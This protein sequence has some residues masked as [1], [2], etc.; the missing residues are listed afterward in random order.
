MKR[1]LFFATKWFFTLSLLVLYAGSTC[2]AASPEQAPKKGS[3]TAGYLQN[4]NLTVIKETIQYME[5]QVEIAAEYSCV[6]DMRQTTDSLSAGQY[7]RTENYYKDYPGG[8]AVYLVDESKNAKDNGGT[9]IKL[10]GNLCC[11]LVSDNDTV[12]PMQFG[13]YGDGERDDHDALQA[14]FGSGFGTIALSGRTYLCNDSIW[15]TKSDVSIEGAGATIVCNDSFGSEQAEGKKS[16]TQIYVTGCT[17]ISFFNLRILDGQ[18]TNH[19]R[20]SMGFQAVGNVTM[21]Y[22]TLHIPPQPGFDKDSGS[23]TLSFADG[24]HDVSVRFCEI[25]NESSLKTGGAVGFNDIYAH[26]SENALFEN[27]VVKYNGKDEVIAIFSHTEGG[28]EV[29]H[30]ASYIRNIMIRHNEFYAPRSENWTRDLGFSVGYE[31]S[32][33]V[34]QV[35]YEENYFEVD[36]VWAFMTFSKTSTN[37]AARGNVIH[38]RQTAEN[39]STLSAFKTMGNPTAVVEDNVI[40]MSTINERIPLAVAAGDLVFRN[41][42]VNVNGSI[43]Y[44]FCGGNSSR[45]N[46]IRVEKDVKKALSYQGGDMIE[47]QIIIQGLVGSIYES[48]TMEMKRDI[49]WRG[50]TIQLPNATKT[51]PLFQFNGMKMNGYVF[52]MENNT[53]STPCVAQNALIIGEALKDEDPAEQKILLDGNVF[54]AF[55]QKNY[56]LQIYRKNNTFTLY[57]DTVIKDYEVLFHTED[58]AQV[59]PQS[60]IGG[61]RLLFP[62]AKVIK[63]WKL[64]GWYRD[65]AYLEPWNFEE[66]TVEENLI[67]YGKYVKIPLES[68]CMDRNVITGV[69]GDTV[70]LTPT[71]FPEDTIET[72]LVYESS[73]TTV[74]TVSDDGVVSL[75][76]VGETVI[77]ITA[78]EQNHLRITIP[79]KVEASDNL[80]EEAPAQQPPVVEPP[81]EQE[82]HQEEL[83][84][85]GKVKKVTLKKKTPSSKTS[86]KRQV[87]ITWTSVKGASH[88][89]IYVSTGKGKKY[90]CIATRSAKKKRTYTYT[91]RKGTTIYVKVRAVRKKS[92]E[93]QYGSFSKVKKIK[94]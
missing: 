75:Q 61:N 11:K 21:E 41:N 76:E 42:Q 58:K 22:C 38:V 81:R 78:K 91:G 63:G 55:H 6:E 45:N 86:R 90:K 67:L 73:D 4:P 88:Y 12:S 16:N 94:L 60:V 28:K 56:K 31:D 34:D 71:F 30:R 89:Q 13:A 32:L 5:P 92:G 51:G 65:N 79:V 46:V 20:T 85:P 36:A 17:N 47:N 40:E 70:T 7:I 8:G 77:V 18:T 59:E 37:C 33:E 27:N 74:A 19:K 26:G 23:C 72:E 50:N 49:L 25:I 93:K 39:A 10:P 80:Q 14:S 3:I 2:L 82:N 53:I 29:F 83:I 44:L 52:S 64:E 84:K 1:R 57:D 66:D 15:V 54:G 9:M 68:F 62:E 24:W 48:Y 87:T 35:V 69:K 43:Q